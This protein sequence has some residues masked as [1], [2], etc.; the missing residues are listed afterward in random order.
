MANEGV[1]IVSGLALGIDAAA[2]TGAIVA[3]GKTIGVLGTPL[4]KSYPRENREL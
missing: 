3:G 1:V 2:H 4:D